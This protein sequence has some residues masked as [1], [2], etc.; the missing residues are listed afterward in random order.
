MTLP[1]P[2]DAAT[3]TTHVVWTSP[4]DERSAAAEALAR[5]A[6]AR[7][8]VLLAPEHVVRPTQAIDLH[9]GDEVE[10]ELARARD[11]LSALDVDAAETALV[12]ARE[13]LRAH[14]ELPQA[15]WLM[16]EVL[17]GWATRW[18]RAEPRDE[19]RAERAWAS[20]AALDGGRVPGL[21][22]VAATA[23]A[24]ADEEDV[25]FEL[26]G[27]AR[28][29]ELSVDGRRVTP[30]HVALTPGEHAVTVVTGGALQWA[31]WVGVARG[32]RVVVDLAGPSPCS[33]EDLGRV[34]ASSL[35]VAPNGVVCASW[36]VV[37]P[38]A[39]GARLGRCER[40]VCGTLVDL[41]ADAASAKKAPILPATT[42]SAWPAWA[43]WAIVGGAAVA[44]TSLTLYSAGAFDGPSHETRFQNGGLKTSGFGF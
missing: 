5:W 2:S 4:A 35:G 31:S 30:G 38:T 22:E 8:V 1:A 14:P 26:R 29:A 12:T 28:F 25:T 6:R 15:A 41:T 42:K 36:L 13:T 3:E 9:S 21:G 32:S 7:G 11:A 27:D 43:T 24:H 17:R 33:E 44:A 20:A 39:S 23:R 10:A 18:A 40:D 37:I 16:A 34:R 19:E